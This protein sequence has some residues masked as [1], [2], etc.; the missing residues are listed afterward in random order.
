MDTAVLVTCYY[1][2]GSKK[3]THED[4]MRYADLLLGKLDVNT[5]I[6][7]Y[8]SNDLTYLFKKYEERLPRLK[9]VV[10]ELY[11]LEIYGR[12]KDHWDHQYSMDSQKSS[13]RTWQCYVIWNSK[14]YFI[15][16]AIR[17]Q[18]FSSDKYIWIDIGIVRDEF[19]ANLVPTFPDA[20]KISNDK[21]DIALLHGF[22]NRN[23][24][25]FKDEVHFA[26]GLF[27]GSAMTLM[28]YYALYKKKLDDYIFNGYF[29]G[30]DQ[31]IVASV[32]VENP[33]LFRIFHALRAGTDPW[34]SMLI[35]Y[36]KRSSL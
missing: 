33:T 21:I 12:Y 16:Q 14:L 15:A 35:Y 30:C 18:Y 26:A 36:N 34:F 7:L 32:Y 31:Q 10:K 29:I 23:Q 17:S 27:G 13:G 4:Y 19:Y 3:R 24:K 25:Y 22:V 2:V 11:D 5:N 6:V 20:S 28:M 1:N 9:I 8:T